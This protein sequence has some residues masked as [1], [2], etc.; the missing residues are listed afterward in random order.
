MIIARVTV[1]KAVKRLGLEDDAMTKHAK[2]EVSQEA[3]ETPTPVE[4]VA[5]GVVSCATRSR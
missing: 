2:R 3:V 1:Q 5:V 4:K